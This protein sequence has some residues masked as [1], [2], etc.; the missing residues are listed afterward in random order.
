MTSHDAETERNRRIA[1]EI[2]EAS[3]SIAIRVTGENGRWVTDFITKNIA[4]YGFSR[5]D[6]MSRKVTW[7]DLVHP[8]DL[9]GLVASID[10]SESRGVFKYN[11][12]YRIR[13]AGGEDVWVSDDSTVVTNDKGEVLYSDCIISDYTET[14]RHIEKIEDHYRQQRVLK[15]ILLGLHDA[16]ADKAVQVVLD[17]AGVYLDISRVLLFEDNPAHTDCRVIHEWTN[18]DILSMHDLRINYERDIPEVHRNLVE[19]GYHIINY[20]DVPPR[21][22]EEF[23]KEGVIAAAI[24]AVRV[25]NEPFGFICFDECVKERQWPDDTIRFLNN[26]SRLVAPAI[27]RKRSEDYL[28][29]RPECNTDHI[30]KS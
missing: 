19:K 6:F 25:N 22:T 2:I 11:N 16:D 3:P 20:G 27:I 30:K 12:I 4:K 8:E 29:S 28:R 21:S 10:D 18:S 17:S 7:M 1:E 13:D 15:G 9:P 5:E 14:K 24:F 23:N 26:V